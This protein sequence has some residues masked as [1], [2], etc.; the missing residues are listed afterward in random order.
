MIKNSSFAPSV[1]A[2]RPPRENLRDDLDDLRAV[3]VKTDLDLHI[4]RLL[5]LHPKL[6]IRFRNQDLASID[7]ATKRTLLDDLNIVLGVRPLKKRKR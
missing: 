4:V 7:E 6:K 5:E 1:G 2:A 3:V